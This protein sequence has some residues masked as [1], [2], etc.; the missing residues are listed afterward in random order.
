MLQVTSFLKHFAPT[1]AFQSQSMIGFSTLQGIQR[2]LPSNLSENLPSL[3]KRRSVCLYSSKPA[4]QIKWQKSRNND[5]FCAPQLVYAGDCKDHQLSAIYREIKQAKLNPDE[6][7]KTDALWDLCKDLAQLGDLDEAIKTALA[8]PDES[9]KNF[10]LWNISEA[11]AKLGKIEKATEVG[12]LISDEKIK[13][14]TF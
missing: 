14:K 4:F 2:Y 6:V 11:L 8:I 13:E 7:E 3:N 9:K 5:L 10:A 12:Q 1:F